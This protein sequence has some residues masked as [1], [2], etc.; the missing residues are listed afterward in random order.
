MLL[1]FAGCAAPNDPGFDTVRLSMVQVPKEPETRDAQTDSAAVTEAEDAAPK[2]EDS[3]VPVAAKVPAEKI[4]TRV[5][6][7]VVPK[8]SEAVAPE[9]V[10]EVPAGEITS[11]V[12]LKKGEYYV[13]ETIEIAPGGELRITAGTTLEF[14]ECGIICYG[15]IIAEGTE[16]DPII[17]KGEWENIT[18]WGEKATGNFRHCQLFNGYGTP[19][20]I[21]EDGKHQLKQ[22]GKFAVGGAILY[23]DGSKGKVEKCQMSENYGRG[24]LALIGVRD[25]AISENQISGNDKEGIYCVDGSPTI[26]G[27]SVHDNRNSG[28]FV[29]GKSEATI[30][31]NDCEGNKLSAME[32]CNEA[33]PVVRKNKCTYQSRGIVIRD[34][35]APV[36]Q[37]NDIL[38]NEKFGIE[39]Y[40]TSSAR[41]ENNLVQG[42]NIGIV[43]MDQSSPIIAGNTCRNQA[44]ACI[45]ILVESRAKV[46]NNTLKDSPT[47]IVMDPTIKADIGDNT[48]EGCDTPRRQIDRK[49]K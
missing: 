37:E 43:S 46:V 14:S 39:C 16:K 35:A 30:T 5:S 22:G 3:S 24:A 4:D 36:L 42:G 2:S 6:E 20:E 10:D 27:N 44:H 38:H 32:V 45:A 9:V 13:E 7:P 48:I 23:G 49:P 11:A 21:R 15:T 18:V 8:I 1:I 28:I 34:K 40:N 47:G 26:S 19:V 33:A 31:G 17:F 12:R 25:V 29:G 41:I